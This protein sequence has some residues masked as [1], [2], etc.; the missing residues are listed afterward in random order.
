M[1]VLDIETSG[2]DPC[3]HGLLSLGA[4][5]CETG[6]T[7]HGDCC[8]T[9]GRAYATEA[10]AINGRSAISLNVGVP[11]TVLVA[12]FG[13]WC[14]GRNGLV[15]GQQVGSFELLFLRE[16]FGRAKL[17]WPFG[18][19][20]VDLHSVAWAKWGESLGLDGILERLG[21]EKEPRPHNALTG[22]KLEAEALRRLASI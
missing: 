12:V 11:D 13:D 7:F 1:I 4:V 14:E 5:D 2:I 15:G 20:C 18:C 21:L 9:Q 16:V 10:L 3:L 8:L 22:A 19:R 6:E 17:H